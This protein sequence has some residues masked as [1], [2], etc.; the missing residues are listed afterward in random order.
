MLGN[1]AGLHTL[2][3]HGRCNGGKICEGSREIADEAVCRE[4]A[5]GLL[6]DGWIHPSAYVPSGNQVK[7][8]SAQGKAW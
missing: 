5:E 2:H 3:L 4:V 7:H 6:K 8:T 1:E